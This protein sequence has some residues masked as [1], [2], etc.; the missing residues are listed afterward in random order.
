[1][2]VSSRLTWPT[3]KNHFH[4][5]KKI[6][7]PQF[8]GLQITK[9]NKKQLSPLPPPVRTAQVSRAKLL[10][11]SGSRQFRAPPGSPA[12]KTQAWTLNP[13]LCLICFFLVL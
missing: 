13:S 8:P 10:L 6:M 1:M 4:E 2:V 7:F 11:N 12:Y 9:Q 5:K 3:H